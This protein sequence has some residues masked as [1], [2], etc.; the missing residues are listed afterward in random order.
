MPMQSRFLFN[1]ERKDST[2]GKLSSYALKAIKKPD[3]GSVLDV[4]TKRIRWLPGRILL[5]VMKKSNYDLL[6]SESDGKIDAHLVVQRQGTTLHVLSTKIIDK[7][8]REEIESHLGDELIKQARLIPGVNRL[9]LGSGGSLPIVGMLK[10]IRRKQLDLGVR[11]VDS[12][13]GRI[14]LL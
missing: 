13:K 9:M 8:R 5:W 14:D 1:I 7:P 11:I 6:I 4:K 2:H 10:S 12:Q 3:R